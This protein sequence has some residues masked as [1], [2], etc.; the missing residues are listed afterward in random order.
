MIIGDRNSFT[1]RDIGARFLVGHTSHQGLISKKRYLADRWKV[2]DKLFTVESIDGRTMAARDQDGNPELFDLTFH[3]SIIP[4]F[5][6]EMM[7]IHHLPNGDFE[8]IANFAE[9]ILSARNSDRAFA[10]HITSIGTAVVTAHL[11]NFADCPG[12]I[13]ENADRGAI[14]GDVVGH[15]F[16]STELD[17]DIGDHE[18]SVG[19][20]VITNGLKVTKTEDGKMLTSVG[21]ART[22]LETATREDIGAWLPDSPKYDPDS[23]CIHS[24]PWIPLGTCDDYTREV[25]RGRARAEL[26]RALVY[27]YP[28]DED[29]DQASTSCAVMATEGITFFDVDSIEDNFFGE[30]V[31]HGLWVY[32]NAT[33]WVDNSWEHYDS[34]LEGDWRRATAEDL[35]HFG[36]TLEDADTELCAIRNIDSVPGIAAITLALTDAEPTPCL[37][38]SLVHGTA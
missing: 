35:D 24:R 21:Q 25:D 26:N 8:Q 13:I 38:D 10:F 6:H 17:I 30:N 4:K 11:V 3:G 34:G 32:E 5:G 19:A 14:D 15:A 29:S 1:S 27:W 16:F 2:A 20:F 33:W 36:F 31:K 18:W 22:I 37:Q 12:S 9:A 23:M 7:W 28:D